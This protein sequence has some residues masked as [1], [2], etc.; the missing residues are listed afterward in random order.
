MPAPTIQVHV[1]WES[2]SGLVF[3]LDVSTLDG[4][5]VLDGLGVTDFSGTYD[6]VTH[7]T[8]DLRIRR[9]RSSKLENIQ[10]G[11]CT[12]RLSRPQQPDFYNPNA[13][14][15]VAPIAGLDPGFAPMR[16]V[17]VQAVYGATTYPLFRGFIRSIEWDSASNQATVE[18]VDLFLWLSRVRPTFT[19]EQ[20]VLDGVT[21]TAAAI[22]YA[23]NESQWTDTDL[24]D[25]GTNVGDTL[26]AS[27][28]AAAE[29]ADSALSIIEGLLETERGIFYIQPDGSATFRHRNYRYTRDSVATFQSEILEVGSGI[30]LDRIV[31]R[32][33]V[34]RTGGDTQ[35]AEDLGL[36]SLYGI[37]D[38]PAID[39]AYLVDDA[40]ADELA[41]FVIGQRATPEAPASIVIDNDSEENLLRILTLDILDR[42]TFP[43]QYDQFV[44][45]TSRFGGSTALFGGG[46]SDYHVEAVELEVRAA[47]QYV[48]ARYTLSGRGQEYFRFGF[49]SFGGVDAAFAY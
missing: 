15:G 30:D 40:Q 18:A 31:N 41:R 17:R 20:A 13:P 19:A 4:V 36:Q 12:F 32:Q 23:L 45:G 35:T 33:A 47:G 38:G 22:E 39:S 1:G 46:G 25:M 28:F 26:A 11:S 43:N 3:R 34:T 14:S 10:A 42:I 37:S 2:L 7:D 48:R 16:P 21:T 5:D 44:F 6:N 8:T 24:I 49:S 27:S 9:G 29:G